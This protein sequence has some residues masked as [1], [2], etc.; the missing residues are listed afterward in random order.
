V[1]DTESIER[2]LERGCNINARFGYD[3][4]TA[5]SLAASNVRSTPTLTLTPTPTLT[6]TPTPTL[7]RSPT[8][9]RECV[10]V[11]TFK[12]LAVGCVAYT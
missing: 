12:N 5:L 3:N 4:E 1:G 11:L 10:C 9:E 7:T 2:A 8:R 6:L